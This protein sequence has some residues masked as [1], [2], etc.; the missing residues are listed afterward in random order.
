MFSVI[1][2]G[3]SVVIR[4]QSVMNRSQFVVN[5][6]LCRP[7]R[8]FR[9]YSGTIR[10]L[11]C[12]GIRG[13]LWRQAWPRIIKD[14]QSRCHYGFTTVG[15]RTFTEDPRIN[16]RSSRNS[17]VSLI[18]TD[19]PEGFKQFK[20]SGTTSRTVQN[21]HGSPRTTTDWI[22]PR[23]A[24]LYIPEGPW[25]SGSLMRPRIWSAICH[26]GNSQVTSWIFGCRSVNSWCITVGYFICI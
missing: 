4:G 23:I 5:P 15:Q 22:S 1:R 2:S 19:R 8:M 10:S 18:L 3:Q 26:V 17:H 12:A 14:W 13:R 25:G 24:E 7:V 6:L 11:S 16:Y 20:T 21:H 9:G